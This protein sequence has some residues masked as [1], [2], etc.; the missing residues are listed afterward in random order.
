MAKLFLSLSL[1]LLLNGCLANKQYQKIFQQKNECQIQ[2][3]NA[4]EPTQI[5]QSEA[6]FTEFF[7]TN[8]QQFQC[9]GVEVV[10]HQ[11]QPQG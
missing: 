9:A 11:I 3:I 10:R 7:D 6:G 1:L 8:E 4:L 2:R 5:V